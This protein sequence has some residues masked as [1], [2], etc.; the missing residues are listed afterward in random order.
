MKEADGSELGARRR[1]RAGAPERRAN[2]AQ[3]DLEHGTGD[4]HIVVEVG[5][6]ALWHGKNPLPCGHM[7]Q[8]VVGEVRGD[9]AHTPGV[10]GGAY[11]AALARERDQP[12][13]AATLTT[14]PRETMGQNATLEVAPEV[15]FDPIRQSVAHGVGLGRSGHEGL[16]VMLHGL[17]QSRLGRAP[18]TVDVAR[19]TRPGGGAGRTRAKPGPLRGG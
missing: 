11:A 17:I 3:E 13:V 14:G 15:A 12:L 5:T 7:R 4:P 10:A 19:E 2:R 18:R 8:H 16:E 6:Q 9:L 1:Y